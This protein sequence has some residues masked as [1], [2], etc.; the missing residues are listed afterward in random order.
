MSQKR[1]SNLSYL[2]IFFILGLIACNANSSKNKYYLAEKFLE[3]HKYEAAISEFQGVV[4]KEPFTE[5]GKTALLKIAQIQ[6]LYLGHAKEAETNYELFLKRNKDLALR[7]EIEKI[8]ANLSFEIFEDYTK[9]I[10]RYRVILEKY[11]DDKDADLFSF[12]IARSYFLLSKF[13]DAINAFSELQKKFPTSRYGA[14]ASLEIATSL[15]TKGNCKDALKQFDKVIAL[16]DQELMPLAKFGKSTCFEEM[17]E[18][19]ESYELLGQIRDKYPV[20]S[21]IDLKM[22]KIKRRKILRRR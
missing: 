8:L 4:D 6:H 15:A 14:R 1:K 5:M 3:D 9:A 18:L 11:P 19:D 12:N 2:A 21:I 16:Q 20:P 17:G 7:A 13:D 10:E 22:A